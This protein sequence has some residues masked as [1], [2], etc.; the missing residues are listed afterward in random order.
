ML[1]QDDYGHTVSQG[2]V[3]SFYTMAQ[4]P[5]VYPVC[6]DEGKVTH[7]TNVG[8]YFTDNKDGTTQVCLLAM[9]MH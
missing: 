5:H 6:V 7:D 3:E 9:H 2:L 4:L 8:S 1:H